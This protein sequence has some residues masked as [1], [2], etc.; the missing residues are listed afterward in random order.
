MK[1]EKVIKTIG[2]NISAIRKIRGISQEDLAFII[3]KTTNTISNIE[4]GVNA[5]KL[6]TLLDIARALDVEFVEFLNDAYSDRMNIKDRKKI[7][8]IVRMLS[9]RS[10]A[11]IA[12]IADHISFIIKL[13]DKK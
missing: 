8:E 5:G 6:E 10:S 12:K 4:R 7:N 3:G 13:A 9:P 2:H 1:Q 11:F